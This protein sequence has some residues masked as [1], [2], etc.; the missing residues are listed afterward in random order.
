VLEG[1]R[2]K[3]KVLED[4]RNKGDYVMGNRTHLKGVIYR[5]VVPT[6]FPATDKNDS[7]GDI[8]VKG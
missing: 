6:V 7:A 8:R 5:G 3:R 2:N 1:K 4:K